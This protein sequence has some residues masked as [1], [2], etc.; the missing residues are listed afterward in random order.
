MNAP[1][2]F[3]GGKPCWGNMEGKME[4]LI[5]QRDFVGAI[6]LAIAFIQSCDPND[7]AGK[8]IRLYPW[9]SARTPA[10]SEPAKSARVCEP[11]RSA[12][13]CEPRQTFNLRRRFTSWILR[14]S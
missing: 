2:V 6:V 1:H 13:V 9:V 11:A 8:D 4:K 7:S 14:S 5:K 12:R 3:P 10:V